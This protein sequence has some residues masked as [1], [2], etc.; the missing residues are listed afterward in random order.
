MNGYGKPTAPRF[1]P[2]DGSP[3]VVEE[4]DG[5]YGPTGVDVSEDDSV[6]QPAHYQSSTGLEAIQCIE[7]ATEDLSG[8]EGYCT[9]NAM[10]YLFRWRKKGGVEDLKKSRWYI[11]RLIKGL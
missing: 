11:D 2:H 6:N 7:A 8:F 9:G 1:Y 10:K 5:P 3:S 4:E